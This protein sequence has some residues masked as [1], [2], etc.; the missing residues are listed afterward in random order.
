MFEN[1]GDIVSASDTLFITTPDDRIGDVWDCIAKYNIEE[2]IYGKVE[3][4]S[5]C[6][7]LFLAF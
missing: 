4:V 7:I 6:S 2:K 1:V 3:Q 5:A